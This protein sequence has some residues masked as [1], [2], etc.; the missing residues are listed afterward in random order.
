M[1]N[2]QVGIAAIGSAVL[3]FA[4]ALLTAWIKGGFELPSKDEGDSVA[5]KPAG[6]VAIEKAD[7]SY[8]PVVV[9]P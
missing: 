5:A 3:L 9:V 4:L 1:S 7:Q 6:I 8:A 2:R